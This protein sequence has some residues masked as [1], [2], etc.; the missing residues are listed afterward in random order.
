MSRAYALIAA[1]LLSFS[2]GGA[3]P[4]PK[5]PAIQS[6]VSAEVWKKA[7]EGRELHS[8][9]RLDPPAHPPEDPK[10]EPAMR[11]YHYAA[12]LG[13]RA[14]LSEAKTAITDYQLYPKMIPY[15]HRTAYTAATNTL[16][17]EGGIW[18]WKTR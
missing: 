3:P 12:L 8:H 18:R 11:K 13:I 4:V 14:P 15:V 10:D 9:A 17:L 6:L 2:A 5:A 7:I 16:E 1:S